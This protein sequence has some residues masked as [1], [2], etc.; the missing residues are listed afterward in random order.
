MRARDLINHS[1][2][3]CE[4]VYALRLGGVHSGLEKT[5]TAFN[6][7]FQPLNRID[8][9]AR[10]NDHRIVAPRVE[11]RLHSRKHLFSRHDLLAGKIPTSIREDLIREEDSRDAGIL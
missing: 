1:A 3:I 8:I 7:G 5:L 4:L 11:G 9:S 10:N 6:R 2:D